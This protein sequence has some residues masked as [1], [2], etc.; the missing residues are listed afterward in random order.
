MPVAHVV[1]FGA[2]PG[3]KALDR[4]WRPTDESSSV[5]AQRSRMP[6]PSGIRVE[7]AVLVQPWHARLRRS[8]AFWLP[9]ESHQGEPRRTGS[10]RDRCCRRVLGA[11]S[12]SPGTGDGQRAVEQGFEACRRVRSRHAAP[13]SALSKRISLPPRWARLALRSVPLSMRPLM[14]SPARKNSIP[15]SRRASSSRSARK[16][17]KA[18]LTGAE[19]PRLTGGRRRRPARQRHLDTGQCGGACADG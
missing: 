17:W 19:N 18:M 4:R 13:S 9:M 10:H 1:G 3:G 7:R 5:I 8:T 11:M 16:R 15:G 6:A 12:V 2:L 14:A